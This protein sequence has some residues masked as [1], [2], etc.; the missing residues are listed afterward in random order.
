MARPARL[1]PF[2]RDVAAAAAAFDGLAET[3]SP[4]ERDAPPCLARVRVDDLG[5]IDD[6]IERELKEMD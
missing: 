3:T 2:A 6:E 5:E 4:L 1:D